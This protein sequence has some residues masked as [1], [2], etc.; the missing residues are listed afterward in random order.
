MENHFNSKIFL[1]T[2]GEGRMLS[3]IQKTSKG[4]KVV[5]IGT[6][7]EYKK[8]VETLGGTINGDVVTINPFGIE[9][10]GTYIGINENT[11]P[12]VFETLTKKLDK[13]FNGL[14]V[15]IPGAGMSV[16]HKVKDAKR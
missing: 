4:E 1:G 14:K 8:L 10:T 5:I 6:E 2:A 16:S 3:G 13:N 11:S 7:K 12:I 15:G 9:A